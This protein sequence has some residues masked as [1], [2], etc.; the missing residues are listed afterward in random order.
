LAESERPVYIEPIEDVLEKEAG[1]REVRHKKEAGHHE[2]AEH[3]EEHREEAEAG[4]EAEAKEEEELKEKEK[5]EEEHKEEL[6]EAEGLSLAYFL[7][8]GV[9]ALMLVFHLVNSPLLNVKAATWRVL[10]MTA[11][12]FVAV[13]LYGTLKGAI[14]HFFEPSVE[15]LVCITLVLFVVFFVGTHVILFALKGGDE[16]R[17]QAGGTIMAHVCGFSAM[18]G[19][20]DGAEVQLINDLGVHGGFGLVVVAA[21]VIT[22]LSF[23]MGV[24]MDMVA[25]DDG[26]VTEDEEAWI[27]TCQETIDDVFCLAISFL[28]VLMFRFLIRGHPQGYEPGKVGNVSQSDANILFTIALGFGLLLPLGAVWMSTAQIPRGLA[29]RVATNIQHL[30][31]MIMSWCFLFWAEWQLYVVGWEHT[32]VGGCLVVAVFLTLSSFLAVILLSYVPVDQSN[33]LLRRAKN[34]VEL[35]LGV[36]VGFSWERAFD[37]GFEV[38]GENFE[39]SGSNKGPAVVLLMSAVLFVIVAP[40]WRYYILPKSLELDKMLDAGK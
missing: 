37:V 9:G 27:D 28:L 26:V 6:L 2:G 35:A 5:E 7:M 14:V 11:S 30:N 25:N 36:L 4:E 32:V 21:V 3:G 34:S 24:V 13:L 31:S 17:L 39:S 8:G 10:N 38:I 1:A 20:A 16:T 15:A 33:K 19:F 22:L 23:I 29:T 12:I 18:Y 40:A